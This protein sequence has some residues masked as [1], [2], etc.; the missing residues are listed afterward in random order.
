MMMT[1][2]L[3]SLPSSGLHPVLQEALTLAV[4]ARAPEEVTGLNLLQGDNNF[5]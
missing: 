3:R 5:M 4:S 1:D 2:E